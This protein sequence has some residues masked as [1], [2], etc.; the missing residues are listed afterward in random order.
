MRYRFSSLCLPLAAG[1]LSL[2]ACGDNL[3]GDEGKGIEDFFPTLPPTGGSQ[4]VFAGEITGATTSELIP[5]P[6]SAGIVGDFFL[7]N[8]KARFV[9]G[10]P[11]PIVGIVTPGGNIVDAVPLAEDGSDLGSDHFGETA[12]I[13]QMGRQCRHT[14]I[15]V[16][17][18]GSEGG[19]A[20]I[21]AS[22]LTGHNE[23]VN[24]RGLGVL[25]IP[26]AILPEREDGAL[27]ATTYILEPGSSTLQ[28]YLTLFN[29][30][31]TLITGPM[32]VL[33]D[34]GG[35]VFI[36]LPEVG[37]SRLEEI[38]DAVS[39]GS[40]NSRYMVWQGPDVAYGIL[41]RHNDESVPNGSVSLL[42]VSV[43]FFGVEE[44]LQSL[45][46]DK[47]KFIAVEAGDGFTFQLDIFA[48]RDAASVEAEY[49]RLNGGS[50]IPLH[51]KVSFSDGSNAAK[52]RIGVFR[53]DD[54]DGEVGEADTV[55]TFI[56]GNAS[57]EYTASLPAGEV[58]LRAEIAG[59][60]QSESVAANLTGADVEVDIT[61][62][63]PVAYDFRIVDDGDADAII[64]GRIMI[65]GERAFA[66]DTR[67]QGNFDTLDGVVSTVIA[68][69]GTSVDLGDGADQQILLPPGDYRVF[70]SRGTEWSI[71]EVRL[72]PESGDNPDELEFRLRRLVD[73]SGYISSEY[74][75]HSLGS[76]DSPIPDERRVATAVA[77]GIEFY[78]TTD[79]DYVTNQQ[80]I[81][82]ELGLENL[83]HSIP[84][85][86]VSPLVYGHFN[87]W[88]LQ[89]D[90]GSPTGGA[91]DWP[92]GNEGF[93][94]TPSEIFA[95]ARDKGAEIVQVNHPRK[96]PGSSSDITEHFDR[97]ALYFDYEAKTF[98]A[99][100]NA[101]PVPID[102]LRLPPEEAQLFSDG[103]NAL[104]VWN[105]FD[106]LD[107]NGDGVREISK[108]DIV[109]RD[110]FN[111]LS[112]GKKLA[113]IA[114][115]DTH[116]EVKDAMGMPRTFVRVTDDS[117]AAIAEG[118]ALTREIMDVLTGSA[119]KATDVVLTDGPLIAVQVDGDAAPLGKVHDGSSGNV[120]I[121][122]DMQSPNWAQVDTIEIFSNATPE[123]GRLTVSALQ[124]VAC[125]TT[126]T[127]LDEADPCSLA[128]IGGA[129][130]LT[131][132][133]VDLGGGFSRFEAAIS[134][135]LSPADIPV[136]DGAQ[137]TDAWFVV[138]V[139]GTDAIYPLVIGNLL[140]QDNVS[141]FVEGNAN[142]VNAALEGRGRPAT[143]LTSAFYVDFDGGG[144]TAQ[145]AP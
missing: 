99:D 31:D 19:A 65:I 94:M 5:G 108:L 41:P 22:G 102:F 26:N 35:E 51:G 10:A 75:V 62:P 43:Y 29:P 4:E 61:L 97:F 33:S 116:T 87:A 127:D 6:A 2:F 96:G 13:Y 66:D 44:F 20:V 28:S 141:T 142:D 46:G 133:E 137:G 122:I 54:G 113:P 56:E 84:G 85:S 48:G 67:L 91:V 104:E 138:R 18:D 16:V 81:I 95:A 37:F 15:E 40:N 78:A 38:A 1:C 83:V 103:F 136:R 118:G 68:K 27:C 32:G 120:S 105:G 110:W 111:F 121:N 8:D 109:M 17:R 144:Y 30:T 53:D 52:V 74:H 139:R 131:V 124:P 58:L 63:K 143:A 3:P 126:R 128:G 77:D 135:S 69:R 42:G 101:M 89:H 132:N 140:N 115:S 107:T 50:S 117:S 14:S 55:L 130:T 129:G 49:Q 86:E 7:R 11:T 70:A 47:N 123:V 106:V 34:T 145:F 98:Q 72:T 9:I 100:V 21:R 76:P 71:A 64:P 73:T 23:Y 24:L 59:V 60:A 134:L 36:F 82:E 92:L 114:S 12:I 88:P 125:F 57:G 90:E 119:G 112:F 79:H 80:P 39:G 25:P 45:Q 93:V